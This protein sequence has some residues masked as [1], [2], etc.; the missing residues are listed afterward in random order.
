MT[1]THYLKHL[2]L[3]LWSL[4]SAFGIS[5]AVI[6]LTYEFYQIEDSMHFWRF[7]ELISIGVGLVFGSL[8]YYWTS[9]TAGCKEQAAAA[10]AAHDENMANMQELV[11]LNRHTDVES[12]SFNVV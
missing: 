4:G 7:K 6:S 2:F 10:T 12:D 9:G 3:L 1:V 8:H 11:G 5:Y